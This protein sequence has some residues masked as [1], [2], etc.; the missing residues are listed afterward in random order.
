MSTISSFSSDGGSRS[1]DLPSP[2]AA[3]LFDLDGTLIDSIPL[4]RESF[5]YACRTVLG[6]LLPDDVLLSRVGMPLEQ[7]MRA[8]APDKADELVRVYRE[9]NH[10]HHD[11]MVR[12]YPGAPELLA[13]LR[14]SGTR[15]G[16]VTSKS[17]WLAERG[18]RVAGL[19]GFVDCLVAAD[20]VDAHKPDPTPIYACLRSLGTEA[21]DS[22]FV[23]DSPFDIESARRAG[24]LAIAIAS[25]PFSEE[26][27]RAAEPAF[28][29]KSIDELRSLLFDGE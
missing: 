20:D 29:V 8:I 22:L 1:L 26:Q 13:R 5:R 7:Q 14:E 27:L 2:L 11:A 17:R 24:V 19:E 15:I 12:A 16:I 4:I 23:G 18:I 21:K 25:G 28:L 3:A 6:T 10:A 9:H